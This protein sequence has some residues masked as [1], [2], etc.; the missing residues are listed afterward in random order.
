MRVLHERDGNTRVLAR[1][2]DV[3]ASTLSRARGLMFRRSIPDDY[4]LVFEFD[5][6]AA[7]DVHMLFVPFPIDA[8]WLV[9]DEVTQVERL[10]SWLGLGRARADVLVELPAGAAGDVDVGDVVRVES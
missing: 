2:V 9:D 6:A 1:D 8:V 10:R 7:R 5:G 4:A 3:A